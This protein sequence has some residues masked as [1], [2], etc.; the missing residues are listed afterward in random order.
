M[1]DENQQ[2]LPVDRGEERLREAEKVLHTGD[3]LSGNLPTPGR[4]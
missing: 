4:R 1:A 2:T 3:I